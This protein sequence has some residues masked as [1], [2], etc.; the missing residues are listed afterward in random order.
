MKPL[1][2]ISND[3]GIMARGLRVLAEETGKFANVYI[4][5][6]HTERSATGHGLS[7]GRDI[8]VDFMEVPMDGVELAY[9]VTGLPAEK[10]DEKP[11]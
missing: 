2:L 3:D 5:A 7:M 6:P 8:Y 11:V 10:P 9:A 4:C 1:I